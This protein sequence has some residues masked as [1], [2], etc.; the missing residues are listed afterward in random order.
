MTERPG[1]ITVDDLH[2][3]ARGAAFLGTGGGGDPYIG[4]LM[5]RQALKAAGGS[6]PL[7]ALEDL[8]DDALVIAVGNMGA[9]TVLIEKLP[10]GDEPTAAVRRLERALGRK[11]DAIIPFEAGGVN[12]L[13][14]LLIAAQTGLP[15]VDGDGM[16]RAFPELQMETFEVYGVPASPMAIVNEYGDSVVIRAH[17]S[18][19][20][21]WIARGVTIRMGG[22]TS[23]A[24]YAMDGATAKRVSVPGTMS[25]CLRLGRCWPRARVE[26]RHPIDLILETLPGTHYRFGARLFDGKIVDLRRETRAGFAIGHLVVEAFDRPATME[27]T[28]QNENLVA[29]QAGEVK[30]IV[31]DLI[32]ILDSETGEPITTEYL[33]YGQ[34][35]AVIGV[36]V[37]EIMRTEEALAVFG[38]AGFG[39]EEPYSPL[40]RLHRESQYPRAVRRQSETTDVEKHSSQ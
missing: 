32:C 5:A 6:V 34:R 22:Q 35:I 33:R 11:A 38:P 21:E 28:F 2:D 15:V 16:G 25:L 18:K 30:A 3:L 31:P 26:G 36:S 37:P 24:E 14:P 9:P 7:V 19:F 29:R 1:H 10:S 27:I 13:F 8:A 23:I 40:E 17:T 20:T 4:R 12:S 39:I